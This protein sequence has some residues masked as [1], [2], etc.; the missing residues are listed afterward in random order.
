MPTQ[1]PQV[2]DRQQIRDVR[3]EVVRRVLHDR[4]E[5]L[6]RMPPQPSPA[7][8]IDDG[9]RWLRRHPEERFDAIV[10]NTTHHFRANVTNLLSVEYLRLLRGHLSDGGIALYNTTGSEDVQ[11]TGA[12]TYP[13]AL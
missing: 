8:V 9:R 2:L 5:A 11:F 12:T 10:Q 7:V 4:V 1:Q 3:T 6:L 13:H